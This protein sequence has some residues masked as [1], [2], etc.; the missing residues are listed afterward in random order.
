LQKAIF[1]YTKKTVPACIKGDTIIDF[2]GQPNDQTVIYWSAGWAETTVGC[3]GGAGTVF[4]ENTD[5][6]EEIAATQDRFNCEQLE[7]HMTPP[8]FLI[9]IS[10]NESATC[11]D[12]SGKDRQ[13]QQT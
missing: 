1:D 7:S 4:A 12:S 10:P 13:L 2:N 11:I 5:G 8:K 3:S 9:A 6:W